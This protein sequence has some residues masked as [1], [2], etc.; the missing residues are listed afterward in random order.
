[1][2]EFTINELHSI[3]QR[4]NAAK[5]PGILV[6]GQAVNLYANHYQELM[7]EIELL[8]PLASRD[9]DFHGGPRDAKRAMAILHATGKINDGTDPSPN[10]GVL[11]VPLSSGQVLIVDILTSVFGISASEM[12]RSSI[13]WKMSDDTTI[14][15][16]HPLLLLESKLACLRSLNQSDR[17]DEKHVRL[18]THVVSA[19]LDEQIESPRHIFKA[20]E[21]IAAMMMTPDGVSAYE[22]GIDLW[23][24]IPLDRMRT[25]EDYQQFFDKRFPQLESQVSQKRGSAD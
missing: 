1:M 11:Q 3:F 19:W 12:L 9:L 7:P 10:A 24:A 17:Q 2:N 15:V 23:Q 21:R 14:E 18:M 22:R 6:G 25:A 5:W 13:T 4:L 16:L 8:R 20:I